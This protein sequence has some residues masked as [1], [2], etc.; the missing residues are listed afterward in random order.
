MGP[1]RSF[2]L[3]SHQAPDGCRLEAHGLTMQVNS[4]EAIRIIRRGRGAFPQPGAPPRRNLGWTVTVREPAS[5]LA[6]SFQSRRPIV[7]V[8]LNES[9]TPQRRVRTGELFLDRPEPNSSPASLFHRSIATTDRAVSDAL[10]KQSLERYVPIAAKL[11]WSLVPKIPKPPVR[12]HTRRV[13][14]PVFFAR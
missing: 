3:R 1:L 14:L 2:C 11:K 12:R 8:R 6:A 7:V 4:R 9:R 5:E 13:R 10:R